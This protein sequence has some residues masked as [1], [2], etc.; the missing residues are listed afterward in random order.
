MNNPDGFIVNG[1]MYPA[2]SIRTEKAMAA[3][4]E[5]LQAQVEA[6]PNKAYCDSGHKFFFKREHHPMLNDHPL[7]PYCLAT[8][9]RKLQAQVDGLRSGLLML[10]EGDTPWMDAGDDKLEG[11]ELM[12]KYAGQL[13]NPPNTEQ[14]T[15][16]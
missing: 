15:T 14:E 13:L 5:E 12:A 7:C 9:N 4:I 10:S 8:D 3:H 16:P 2:L 11:W 1:K 6:K